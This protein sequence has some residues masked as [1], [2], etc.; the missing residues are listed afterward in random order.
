MHCIHRHT[1]SIHCSTRL[2]MHLSTL[3]TRVWST[4]SCPI[5]TSE[6]I[7]DEFGWNAGTT[8]QPY[9]SLEPQKDLRCYSNILLVINDSTRSPRKMLYKLIGRQDL[10]TEAKESFLF[11]CRLF[12][13]RFK[14]AYSSW[15]ALELLSW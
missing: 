6:Y 2:H 12:N 8:L 10:G 4:L 13:L 5:H 15:I 11:W 14:L 1:E 9:S 7:K 3:F